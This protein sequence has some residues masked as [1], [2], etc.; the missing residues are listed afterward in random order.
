[1]QLA[2]TRSGLRNAHLTWTATA[3]GQIKFRV[4]RMLSGDLN[5][6][7]VATLDVSQLEYYDLNVPDGF[8]FFYHIVA[9]NQGGEAASNMV[10]LK[11]QF[12]Q[13][14]PRLQRN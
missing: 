4:E 11:A 9:V 5:W 2:V 7:P 3:G 1:M 12:I 10:L 6:I 8:T 13:F 14:M